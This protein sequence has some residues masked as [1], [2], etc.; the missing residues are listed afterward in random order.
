LETQAE[1]QAKQE[2]VRAKASVVR[3]E[4]YAKSLILAVLERGAEFPDELSAEQLRGILIKMTRLWRGWSQPDLAK[5]SGVR[6]ETISRLEDGQRQPRHSTIGAL[7]RAMK[8]EPMALDPGAAFGIWRDYVE[9]EKER[10]Q[11]RK[12]KVGA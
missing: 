10:E 5:R 1:D 8:V 3:D 9:G 7:A 4:L 11:A 12:V 2:R 6:V